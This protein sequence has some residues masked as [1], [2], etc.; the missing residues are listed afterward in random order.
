MGEPR[1]T[2]LLPDRELEHFVDEEGLRTSLVNEARINQISKQSTIEMAKAKA[3][4]KAKKKRELVKAEKNQQ[5][6]AKIEGGAAL[7]PS[8][9]ARAKNELKD[10][11]MQGHKAL[12][13]NQEVIV[14][15]GDAAVTGTTRPEIMKL[16]QKLNINLDVQLTRTDTQN[17]LATILTCNEKQL[18]ALID[19]P[20]IPIGIKIVIKRLLDDAKVGDMQALEK[21]WDRVFGKSALQV[22]P[23]NQVSGRK[24]SNTQNPIQQGSLLEGIIPNQPISREAYILIRETVI[25]PEV[26]KVEDSNYTEE[27]DNDYEE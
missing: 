8:E 24:G 27:V 3:A 15:N 12:R 11:G 22:E 2:K 17:F 9:L 7:T 1:F 4:L 25:G 10:L 16:M 21:V 23:T 19:N 14:V 13:H 6:I 26:N 18:K 20:R 5:V